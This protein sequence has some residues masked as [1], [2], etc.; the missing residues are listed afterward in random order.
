MNFSVSARE[1]EFVGERKEPYRLTT[2]IY[3]NSL[4]RM[5]YNIDVVQSRYISLCPDKE[6]GTDDEPVS[7][8]V[9]CYDYSSDAIGLL[10]LT[11]GLSERLDALWSAYLRRSYRF[12]RALYYYRVANSK[13]VESGITLPDL[14]RPDFTPSVAPIVSLMTIDTLAD[15]MKSLGPG[16]ALVAH[17]ILPHGPY[18]YRADCSIGSSTGERDRNE[19][20]K[21]YFEQLDCLYAKLETLVEQMRVVGIYDDAVV[22]LHGDHGSR[23]TS[24]SFADEHGAPEA[25][26]LL[27]E[28][29]TLFAVKTPGSTASIE[30]APR[31]LE[32][33]LEQF[34]SQLSQ[35]PDHTETAVDS[36]VYLGPNV[37][38]QLRRIPYPEP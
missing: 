31:G 36:F 26:D 3:F 35:S 6:N 24:E 4:V 30:V 21:R 5:G 33:L 20:Y 29:S 22:I 18:V 13:L 23:I 17:L 14:W 2:N 19:L 8:A 38:G 11:H 28:Y 7:E 27:D 16:Q 32:E 37:Q 12:R 10:R 34:V 9:R 25:A 1:W 15:R